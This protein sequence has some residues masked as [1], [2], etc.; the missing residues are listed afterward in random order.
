MIIKIKKKNVI[1][2]V[3]NSQEILRL[4]TKLR[5]LKLELENANVRIKK[6]PEEIRIIN[7]EITNLQNMPQ[8]TQKTEI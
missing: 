4:Q 7:Q 5:A 8:E 3:D 2:E 6:I 1:E